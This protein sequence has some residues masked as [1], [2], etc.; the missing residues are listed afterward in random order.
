MSAFC[1]LERAKERTERQEM[2]V[3]C[4]MN[5]YEPQ[6]HVRKELCMQ[7]ML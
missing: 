5:P 3:L 7:T 2:E 4:G 6:L 1:G